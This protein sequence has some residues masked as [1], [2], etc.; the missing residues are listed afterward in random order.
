MGSGLILL[1]IV[2]AWLAVLVPMA[3]RSHDTASAASTVDRFS[4]AMRVL[5]RRSA[6]LPAPVD[7]VPLVPARAPR[8]PRALTPAA[9][10]RRVLG[11]LVLLAVATLAGVVVGPV[12]LLVPHL[13]ADLLLVGVLAW[14]RRS[15]SAAA[16]VQLQ[17]RAQVQRRA[18]TGRAAPRRREEA[19]EVP[20][21]VPVPVVA[22]RQREEVVFDQESVPAAPVPAPAVP[23]PA[24]LAAAAAGGLPGADAPTRARG[25]QGAPWQPVPVPVPTY[26]TAART[27]RLVPTPLASGPAAPAARA[28]AERGHDHDARSVELDHILGRR[29]VGD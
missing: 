7:D 15:R 2:G 29:A 16:R 1:L 14:L 22:P 10:R 25:A 5:S 18:G 26:V 11:V 20:A 8:E 12:W 17:E 9:R 23:A 27:P 28:S 4:D 21:A 19:A 3:L 24:A 6:G 13:V